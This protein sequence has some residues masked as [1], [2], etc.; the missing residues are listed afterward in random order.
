MRLVANSRYQKIANSCL[1]VKE[2][3]KGRKSRAELAQKLGLQ[4]STVTYS[5]ARLIEAGLLREEENA[6]SDGSG[7]KGILLGLDPGYGLVCGVELLAGY[8]RIV[9]ADI[10]GLVYQN[11]VFNY[12]LSLVDAEKGTGERFIQLLEN[13]RRKIEELRGKYPVRGACIAIAGIVS[14]DYYT[15]INSWTHGLKDVNFKAVLS[16]FS[17]P[18]WFENDA[19]AAAQKYLFNE[20]ISSDSF[21]YVLV[22]YYRQT[23]IP[24]NVPTVGIGIGI[25]IEGE[26]YRGWTN[27]AGEFRSTFYSGSGV[28]GQLS[29]SNSQL[30]LLEKDGNVQDIFIKELMGNLLSV[31]AVLNPRIIY[32]GGDIIKPDLV[33]KAMD[34]YFPDSDKGN[35]LCV[36]VVEDV[37]WDVSYGACML[38]LD[39][40]FR[41]PKIGEQI[42]NN[43]DW[44][45]QIAR[46]VEI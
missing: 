42:P 5:T 9:L 8:F 46:G 35:N 6:V 13:V 21:F 45:N 18:V 27:R 31:E 3:T 25:V 32:I 43:W 40:M 34:F 37:L 36:S 14:R 28:A 19:N 12:D 11:G 7:R 20:K 16:R 15:I 2:L 24:E 17:Y 38:V 22:H 23:S 30:I 26:L 4:P 29:L 41:I 39:A 1:I 33:E 10:S 44:K